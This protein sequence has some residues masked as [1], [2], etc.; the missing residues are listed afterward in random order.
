MS[1]IIITQTFS[2]PFMVRLDWMFGT[3]AGEPFQDN[4]MNGIY[5]P[6]KE[7]FTDTN[8]N[9][10]WDADPSN[11]GQGG[12]GDVVVYR[13]DISYPRLFPVAKLMGM[14]PRAQLSATTILKN[15][16]YKTQVSYTPVQICPP[17]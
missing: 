6:A 5:D 12:A 13:M 11:K 16:P 10:V 9:K 3:V 15:Q 2:A 7:C 17:V 8:N 1:G 14:S 4:N